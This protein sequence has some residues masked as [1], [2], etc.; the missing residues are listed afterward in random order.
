MPRISRARM[1]GIDWG[2]TGFRAYRLASGRVVDRREAACGIITIEPGGFEAALR[3]QVGD[4]IK[5]GGGPILLAGMVGSRQGWIEAPYLP[6]PAGADELGAALLDVPCAGQRVAIVPGL[7]SFDPAGT[8]EVM[9]GE[10]TQLAGL[11]AEMS[12]PGLACLPGTHSK[13]ARI[14]DG[15]VTSFTTHMTGEVFAALRG[16]TILGRMMQDGPGDDAAFLDG[17]ART[18]QTGGL[19]HHLF[20]VRTLGLFDRLGERAAA[21]YLSGLLIGHEIAAAEAQGTVHLI[22]APGL[23]RLYALALGQR[24]VRTVT[25]A[26][27]IGAVG[28]ALIAERAG[29][30]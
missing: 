9:R 24:R 17:V 23:C 16:H 2:T 6:C 27:D 25:A 21:S 11:V 18:E 13:W 22:G 7:R 20:G 8:P 15:R 1:I 28:L 26:A 4:W 10:E 3:D 30:V 14:V 29:W 12:T 19:L 5:A